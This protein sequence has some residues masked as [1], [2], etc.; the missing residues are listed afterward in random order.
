MSK[1]E[2]EKLHSYI[3]LSLDEYLIKEGLRE[4][5]FTDPVYDEKSG[6]LISEG[7]IR[8]SVQVVEMMS[9]LPVVDIKSTLAAKSVALPV[10][11]KAVRSL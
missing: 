1:D 4:D 9:K 7:T 3:W 10:S 11:T 5:Y 8:R 6:T 2:F